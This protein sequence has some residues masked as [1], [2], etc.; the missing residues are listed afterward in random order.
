MDN[1]A[2]SK[3]NGI[4]NNLNK[5]RDGANVHAKKISTN[6]ASILVE[7][8]TI[9]EMEV[10]KTIL[11]SQTLFELEQAK[12]DENIPIGSIFLNVQDKTTHSMG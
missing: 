3:G 10:F 8:T 11:A 1:D 6:E 12:T 4:P 9:H 7:G 5:E 2:N